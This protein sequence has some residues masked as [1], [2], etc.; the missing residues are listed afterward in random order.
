MTSGE[1][2]RVAPRIDS[3]ERGPSQALVRLA[4]E[5]REE[6]PLISA[7]VAEA[8]CEPVLGVLV[9]SGPRCAPAPDAY[10]AVVESVREGYLLHYGEPR[11]LA[12]LEPDLR[13]LIGD[14]LYARGIERLAGLG[15][16][17]AVRELA[18]LISLA[19]QLD[20]TPG[21]THPAQEAAWLAST[22]AIATG[23]EPSLEQAKAALRASAD[24]RPLWRETL[25][26]AERAGLSAALAK[27]AE[28]VGFSALDLG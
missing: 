21:D 20:A 9:A 2:S 7:Q 5:L 15:D 25:L 12:S 6:G 18:D 19:A 27:A 16:L 26:V 8:E 14:H 3:P 17:F 11:L 22:V 4:A 24:A 13:L 1:T 28:A 23:P 10:A